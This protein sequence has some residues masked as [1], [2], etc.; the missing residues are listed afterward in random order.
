MVEAQIPERISARRAELSALEEQLVMQLEKVRAERDELA[1]AEPV[2]HRMAGQLADEQAVPLRFPRRWQAV[3]CCSS[4]T[5][6]ATW[7][8]PCG[9]ALDLDTGVRGKLEPCGGS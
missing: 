4:R 8:R 6:K 2:W 1:V 3:R 7:P 5:G 9:E